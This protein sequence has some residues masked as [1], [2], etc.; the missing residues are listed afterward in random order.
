MLLVLQIYVLMVHFRLCQKYML[1]YTSCPYGSKE[2]QSDLAA[3]RMI[4]LVS[5]CISTLSSIISTYRRR[6]G[7]GIVLRNPAILVIRASSST[8]RSIVD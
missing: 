8:R 7:Y 1:P 2:S 3:E 4:D 6:F 5:G